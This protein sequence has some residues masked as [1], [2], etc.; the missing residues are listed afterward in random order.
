MRRNTCINIL[1]TT[2][3]AAAVVILDQL[4]KLWIVGSFELGES[5]E[6][7]SGILN[8]TYIQNKGA[9]LGMLSEHRWIFMIL[10]A[11][12][13]AAI[14]LFIVF[15]KDITRPLVVV[16]AMILGGGIGNM[17]DRF[18][19]GYVIDFIDVKFLPFWKWI[20]NVADIFV[21]VGAVLLAAVYILTE[22]KRKKETGNDGT[23][24]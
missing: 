19:Y 3:I 14:L 24:V 22:L 6:V 1:I 16:L 13:I 2:V 20:F 5:R 17:I 4:S 8:W 21:T 18:A 7:L 12:L 11:V 23:N 10:S 9:A 15:S